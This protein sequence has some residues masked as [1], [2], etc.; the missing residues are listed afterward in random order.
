MN[1]QASLRILVLAGLLLL[2][3]C[4]PSE[5]QAGQKGYL[6]GAK[7]PN[8]REKV[9]GA[10][11]RKLYEAANSEHE[12]RAVCLR[13]IDEGLIHQGGSIS[14]IDEIFATQFA[15]KLRNGSDGI[16]HDVILFAVQPVPPP[17]LDG[18]AAGMDY[19][20]WYLAVAYDRT[21]VIQNYYL[22]N[23]HKGNDSPR[24][25]GKVSVPELRRLYEMA[26][27]E[28]DRRAVCLRAIDEGALVTYRPVSQVDEIA[29][30]H[31]ASNLP[32]RKESIRKTSVE[33]VDSKTSGHSGWFLAIEYDFQGTLLNYYLTNIHS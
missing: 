33:F 11:L 13:A 17:R 24:V 22:T 27:S 5:K 20:G 8:E 26:Q 9:S 1:K 18:K 3:C 25:D 16:S 32:S 12:R 10:E 28:V 7:G 19:V 15:S 31:F 23:L 30:T 14:L 21:G 29:Q 2:C 6:P 4:I